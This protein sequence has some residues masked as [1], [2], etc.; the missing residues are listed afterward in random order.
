MVSKPRVE[1]GEGDEPSQYMNGTLTMSKRDFV[2]YRRL[3]TSYGHEMVH[4]YVDMKLM[5]IWLNSRVSGSRFWFNEVIAH[6]WST[7]YSGI[8]WKD[9][10]K[11]I[12]SSGKLYTKFFKSQKVMP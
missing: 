9:M 11:R 12:G 7:A 6:T 10:N 5:G 8:K 2:T 4:R 1:L 3:A